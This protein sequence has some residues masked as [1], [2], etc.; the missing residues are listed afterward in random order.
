VHNTPKCKCNKNFK[1]IS[2]NITWRPALEPKRQKKKKSKEK[3]QREREL[4]E[5]K[6][7]KKKEEG[8][9]T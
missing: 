2:N 9:G 5:E 3:V 7:K 6:R 1:Q 4:G 8:H